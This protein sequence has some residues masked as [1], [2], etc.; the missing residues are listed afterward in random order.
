MR[1]TSKKRSAAAPTKVAERATDKAPHDVEALRETTRKLVIELDAFAAKHAPLTAIDHDVFAAQYPDAYCEAQGTA[2]R[3]RGVLKDAM[4]WLRVFHPA[5]GARDH[6]DPGFAATTLPLLIRWTRRLALALADVQEAGTSGAVELDAKREIA[7]LRYRK[8]R[9]SVDDALGRN[10]AWITQLKAH[11]D[12]E[13]HAEFDAEAARLYR[14]ADAIDAWLAGG[15]ALLKHALAG[16]GVTADVSKACREAADAV[17]AARKV[18]RNTLDG[19]RDTP[20]INLVEGRVLVLMQD[21]FRSVNK[22]RAE[23]KTTLVLRPGAASRRIIQPNKPR[24][25]ETAPDDASG[26]ATGETPAA[27]ATA[28][29]RTKKRGR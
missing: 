2:T 21:V 17:E 26:A 23:K 5:P 8:T 28:K 12:G 7:R 14:L 22:A 19:G 29:K 3:S 6:G 15:D 18:T 27:T 4:D 24:A 20:A 1:D 11:L 16:R 9:A 25:T 13:T 10:E